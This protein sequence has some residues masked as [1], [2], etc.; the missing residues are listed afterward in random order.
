M[1]PQDVKNK[2]NKHTHQSIALVGGVYDLIHPGHISYLEKAKK[3][4]DILVVHVDSDISVRNRKGNSRPIL[5]AAQRATMIAALRCV[6]YVCI[7]DNVYYEPI[8]LQA[9]KPTVIV[10]SARGESNSSVKSIQGI[11]VV[12]IAESPGVHTTSIIRK[13]RKTIH[14]GSSTIDRARAVANN[15]YSIS[16]LQIGAAVRASTGEIFTG[17]NM[18]NASPSLAMCAERMAIGAG[19]AA[20]HTV[21]NELTVYAQK[22]QLITPCGLC[23]QVFYEF[24]NNENATVNITSISAEQSFTIGE[25]LPF[26]YT[27][28][29]I[30]K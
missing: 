4:A 18:S 21:F 8:I 28:L 24:A 15:G 5:S 19:V 10:R 11:P 25:L 13:L 20:G 6:D 27:T 9:V 30:K 26:A 2:L 7:S 1:S 14:D 22:D 12:Y 3:Y 17:V 16:G 29:R 23:R